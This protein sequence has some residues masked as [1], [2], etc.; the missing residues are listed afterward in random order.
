V[1]KQLGGEAP[2]EPANSDVRLGRTS[3]SRIS[4]LDVSATAT[5]I[6]GIETESGDLDGVNLIPFL[7]GQNEAAPHDALT[8]RRVTSG[9][10]F[11]TRFQSSKAATEERITQRR[12]V[13]EPNLCYFA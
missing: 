10:L 2:S 13:L 8:W 3:S 9:K 6:T 1:R 4:A 5:G 12:K 11:R 7:S